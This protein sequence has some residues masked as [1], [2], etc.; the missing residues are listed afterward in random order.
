MKFVGFISFQ[1]KIHSWAVVDL[2]TVIMGIIMEVT[3]R[4]E[5]AKCM[6]VIKV[7]WLL[8]IKT[9]IMAIIQIGWV[10]KFG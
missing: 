8:P 2:A 3:E 4:M 1:A 10:C 9:D 5:I 7:E 6:G